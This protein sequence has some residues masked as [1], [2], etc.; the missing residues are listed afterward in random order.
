[1][2]AVYA[3]RASNRH[4]TVSL[5]GTSTWPCMAQSGCWLSL[6]YG[7]RGRFAE[8][9]AKWI[10]AITQELSGYRK[11][12]LLGCENSKANQSAIRHKQASTWGRPFRKQRNTDARYCQQTLLP[13][14]ARAS[15]FS[16][17]S[18]IGHCAISPQPVQVLVSFRRRLSP[19]AQGSLD[20]ALNVGDLRL[21]GRLRSSYRV[22]LATT[23]IPE[24]LE[25]SVGV[26]PSLR[27]PCAVG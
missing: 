19:W 2:L 17:L 11:Q 21:R 18:R 1:M 3:F 20:L 13:C 7:M 4:G 6:R 22:T 27:F 15:P 16:R 12:V 25:G 9:P 8:Y 10:S 24:S 5:C 14:S 26:R 23:T